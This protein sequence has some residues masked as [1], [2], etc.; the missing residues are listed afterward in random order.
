M[1]HK[2]KYTSWYYHI[3]T[4]AKSQERNK[5]SKEHNNYVYYEKHHII[6]K[7]LGGNDDTDNV[8]LLT[9]REHFIA[10]ILLPKMCVSFKHTQQMINALFRMKQQT[11]KQE[12]YFNNRLYEYT[13]SKIIC[14]EDKKKKHKNRV[15]CKNLLTGEFMQ[16][17]KEIFDSS[18]NL[19]GVNFGKTGQKRTKEFIEKR[20]G[21]NNSFYGRNHTMES[22]KKQGEKI[23]QKLKGKPKTEEHKQKMRDAW[24]RRKKTILPRCS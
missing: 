18:P 12:R 4:R 20:K 10:H 8:V 3:V 11:S 6:P 16:V 7:S 21:K 14:S 17:S 24:I 19:V 15:S 23:S 13:K 9:A 2:N 5:L 22:K 1:F